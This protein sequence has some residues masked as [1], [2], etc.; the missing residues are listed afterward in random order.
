MMEPP[1]RV[2]ISAYACGPK[3]GSEIGVGW[4]WVI[5]IARHC[6]VTVITESGFRE[7]ILDALPRLNLPHAPTFHFVDI[8]ETA[9]RRCWNQGDWRFYRD[10]RRWQQSA[11]DLASRLIAEEHFDVCHHLNMIGYREP[12]YLWRLPLPFVWGPVGGHEQMPW[13]F[14]P[15]L[16]L[17]AAPYYVARN[18]LNGIQARTAPRVRSAARTAAAVIVATPTNQAALQHLHGVRSTLIVET[19]TSSASV[20]RCQSAF[21]GSRPLRVCWCGK[22][23]AQKALPIAL[24]ALAIA[25]REIRVELDI[26]GDG[27]ER[28][29]W[30]QLSKRLGVDQN[31]RWLGKIPHEEALR[32]IAESDCMLLTS[33]QEATSTVVM[34]ALSAGVPVVCHDSCGFGAVVDDRCGIKVPLVSPSRSV[35]GF[36][37][38]LVRLSR[39]P[40]LVVRLS[41][42][43]GERACEFTWEKKA[44]AVVKL[45]EIVLQRSGRAHMAAGA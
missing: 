21:D 24:R 2:L 4:N 35:Q 7:D 41:R 36:A 17:K 31:C 15:A 39:D 33:I 13:R 1:P 16:G 6:A 38:A 20:R 19:G 26:I 43:A 29:S 28:T 23:L 11:Y 42:G 30:H 10:Y 25:S 34:E 18:L 45:Y 44:E 9:R 22:F 27:R 5:N 37:R 12:G 40:A 8:G 14:I 32:A 3:W